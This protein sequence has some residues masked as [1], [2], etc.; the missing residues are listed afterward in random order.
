MPS[1]T[2][3]ALPPDDPPGVRVTSYGLRV[4]PSA[5]DAV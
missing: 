3:A 5:G 4:M 2:A 1:A